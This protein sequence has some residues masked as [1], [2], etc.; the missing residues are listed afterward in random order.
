MQSREVLAGARSDGH[1]TAS[2][3]RRP[4]NEL[5]HYYFTC[6]FVCATCWQTCNYRSVLH[7]K[8]GC[9]PSHP[10]P[11]DHVM[12]VQISSRASSPTPE[13]T[14]H[15]FLVLSLITNRNIPKYFVYFVCLFVLHTICVA[16]TIFL[17]V[18]CYCCL[19]TLYCAIWSYDHQ[20][21]INNNNNNTPGGT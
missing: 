5:L 7:A 11:C 17:L 18:Y 16:E 4:T 9:S 6:G 1:R 10:I 2:V 8:I 21:E 3:A 14:R 12:S 13:N 20:V 15:L 19:L